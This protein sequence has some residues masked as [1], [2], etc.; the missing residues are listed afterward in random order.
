MPDAQPA[1]SHLNKWLV[2]HNSR[3]DAETVRSFVESGQHGSRGSHHE[4]L[5]SGSQVINAYSLA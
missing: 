5:C 3:A 1:L 4:P 2:C